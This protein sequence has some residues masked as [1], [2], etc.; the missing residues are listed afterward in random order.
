MSGICGFVDNSP[1]TEKKAILKKMNEIIVHRGPDCEGSHVDEQIALAYRSLNLSGNPH[2]CPSLIYKLEHETILF[3]GQLY[4][5]P[6]LVA[7]LKVAGYSFVEETAAEA[8]LKAYRL[9]GAEMFDHLRG[10]FSF[11][12]WNKQDQSLFAARDFFGVRP[13]Y[14]A[15]IAEGL[16]FGSEIKSILEHP[17]VNKEFNQD[18]LACYLSFQYSV[19]PE[20]FFKGIYRLAP[21][22][23][24]IYQ[25]GTVTQKRY[26]DVDFSRNTED[27]YS[28]EEWSNKIEEVMQESIKLHTTSD[29]EVGSF[30]SSG[31]DSSYIAASFGGDKTFTVGFRNELYNEI[32]AAESL[33]K[34]INIKNYNKMIAPDDF[35]G[36]IP[37]A[38]YLMDEPL[39]DP[40]A[41]ALYFVSELA[42][43]H[44][45]V[46][47]SGEGA[48]ELFAGYNIYK[49]PFS[50][51]P[52]RHLPRPLRI[53]LGKLAEAFPFQVKGKNYLIRA[54]KDVED[55]FIGNANIFSE[56]ERKEIL[57]NDIAD[58]YRNAALTRPF[59][60]RVQD[61]D[62]V[63]KMQY[64]D[65]HFWM[66]GDILLKADRMTTANSIEVRAPFVDIEVAKLATKLPLEYKVSLEKTK[67]ALRNTAKRKLAVN[68]ADKRKLGFPVPTRVWLREE[69]YYLLVKELFN[70]ELAK[71]FFKTNN[72]LLLLDKHYNG[73][74]D[75][76]RKIWTVYCFL[77]WYQQYFGEDLAV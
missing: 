23:Y 2:K 18:A 32:T 47:L 53:G 7:E 48:D 28:L 62:D 36:I 44:V 11:V 49:E 60:K 72:L 21:G 43:G 65:I 3:S 17:A 30:L 58:K 63:V 54:S 42:S 25:N 33:A 1:I 66:A 20:T 10:T 9:Y 50:L 59:Y 6:E 57:R 69:K 71:R 5:L 68:V 35:W 12:I 51:A 77:V 75:N 41:I 4:N 61:F 70:S 34:V 14:Y 40:A 76:S 26:F 24:M 46:V 45:K 8:T 13:L 16:V 67:L 52:M 29:V 27:N 15:E 37:R 38:Q 55:R 64:I 56:A 22:S 73:V 19:L 74:T 39:A 31:V